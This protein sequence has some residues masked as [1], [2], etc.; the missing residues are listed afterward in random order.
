MP[1][2]FNVQPPRFA[3]EELLS[4]LKVDTRSE[5]VSTAEALGRVT[6]RNIISSEELPAFPRSSM[7]GY[8]VRAN[9][10]FGATESLSLIHI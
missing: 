6:A 10:T 2:F 9:D 8:S 4:R 3:L 1:E 7:D 5:C